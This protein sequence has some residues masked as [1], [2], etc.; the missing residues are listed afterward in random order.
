[1]IDIVAF[2]VGTDVGVVITARTLD[3]TVPMTGVSCMVA[4]LITMV[5]FLLSTSLF[6]TD[7]AVALTEAATDTPRIDGLVE[8][9]LEALINVL[10]VK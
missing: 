8:T 2:E 3:F 1:M 4:D 10:L 7:F 5:S 9:V 6:N